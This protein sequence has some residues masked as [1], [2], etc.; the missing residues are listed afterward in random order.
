MVSSCKLSTLRNPLKEDETDIDKLLKLRPVQQEGGPFKGTSILV[1]NGLKT[2]KFQ[3]VQRPTVVG[4][5]NWWRRRLLFL[6]PPV[7]TKSKQYVTTALTQRSLSMLIKHF[8][9]MDSLWL[10]I[11]L[12]GIA[13]L[14]CYWICGKLN[15]VLYRL[16]L[17]GIMRYMLTAQAFAHA[18]NHIIIYTIIYLLRPAIVVP[19]LN[20][21]I[22]SFNCSSY[23]WLFLMAY[24]IYCVNIGQ[25]IKFVYQVR[26]QQQRL[27]E[28][29]WKGWQ[30]D[31]TWIKHGTSNGYWRV[32]FKDERSVI[33]CGVPA[34]SSVWQEAQARGRGEDEKQRICINNCWYYLFSCEAEH[35][36]VSIVPLL[37]EGT[38]GDGPLHV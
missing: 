20:L 15:F 11:R 5:Q 8:V 34:V 30:A 7:Q 1:G 29:H 26:T 36:I 10:C 38:F 18:Q 13:N 19:V 3:M 4:V 35:I 21:F 16:S 2:L 22:M 37:I 24:I 9:C 28:S 12:C 33:I 6:M 32:P 27:E 17:P 25:Y 31:Q 23:W 14:Q